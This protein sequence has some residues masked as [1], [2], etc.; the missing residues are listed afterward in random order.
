MPELEMDVDTALPL[1]LIVNELLT[2][3]LKYAFPTGQKGNIK[4]SLRNLNDNN[5]QLKISDNGVG[6]PFDIKAK[7]TGFGTQLVELLTRQI[8]GKLI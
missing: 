5:F 7:G 3:S 6:K 8:D 2:N 1:G 4:L